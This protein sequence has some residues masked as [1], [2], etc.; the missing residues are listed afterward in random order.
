MFND[1]VCIVVIESFGYGCYV[2]Y[3]KFDWDVVLVFWVIDGN[4][5]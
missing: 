2:I 5:S 3:W 1:S 4:D